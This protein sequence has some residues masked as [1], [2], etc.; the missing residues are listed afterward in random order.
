MVENIS[1]ETDFPNKKN[2]YIIGVISVEEIKRCI[3]TI[4]LTD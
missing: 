2:K 4:T 3:I 1:Y